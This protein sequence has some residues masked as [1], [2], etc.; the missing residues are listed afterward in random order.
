MGKFI[1]EKYLDNE[2]EYQVSVINCV[3]LVPEEQIDV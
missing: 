2:V 1:S 3:L